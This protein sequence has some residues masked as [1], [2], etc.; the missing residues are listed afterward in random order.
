VAEPIPVLTVNRVGFL[1]GV[2][3]VIITCAV[4]VQAHGFRP[5]IACPAPGALAD[6]ASRR[7]IDVRASQIDRTKATLSPSRW[8]RLLTALGAGRRQIVRLAQQ[9][10]VALLHA[11]HPVGALYALEAARSLGIPLVLHVHETLP[12]R[13]LYALLARHVIPHCAAF[14]CVSE[15]SR[16]LMRRLGVPEHSIR[17]IHNSVDESFLEPT[18]PVEELQG[19]GPHIGLFGVLERRKGQADF[20]RAA[21][22]LKDRHSTA[23]FWIVG[24]LSF[25]DNADYLSELRRLAVVSGLAD[26]V[27]FTGYRADIPNLMAGMDAVVLG[28]RGRESL[29]T[30]LIEA[31]TLGRPVAAT[32]VGGV[33]EIIHDGKTGLIVPRSDPPALA[34]AITRLLGP[35][36]TELAEQARVDARRRFSPARFADD[37]S[38]LYRT[39]LSQER[40]AL[41][42]AA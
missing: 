35:E 11:H 9:E 29:P 32:E 37:I 20:I 15:A 40:Q 7:G 3:R 25:A 10:R 1:G 19:T 2:E 31:C 42:H 6:E 4:G 30:V 24:P 13:P 33:R 26:R 23:Q 22:L 34:A 21:A 16:A 41:E 39:Q 12:L 36:G 38:A 8:L 5:I 18:R 28:S 14:V 27:H 17:V